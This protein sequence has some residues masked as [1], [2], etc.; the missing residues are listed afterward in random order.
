M[1]FP[2]EQKST[3]VRDIIITVGRTGALT[4]SAVLAPVLVGGVTVTKATLHNEDE[5]RRKDVHIGDHV[6]VQRAG[7][8]IPEIVE[9]VL[10]KRTGTERPFVMPTHCPA[11]NAPAVRPEGEAVARCS[12]LVDC[13][14]QIRQGIIH[15]CSRGA[16]DIDGLGEKL[17]DQFVTVG[18]VNTVADLYSLTHAQLTDLERI[19]DKSAQNLVDAIHE[20]KRGHSTAH[21]LGLAFA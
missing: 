2:P 3:V 21:Y 17:V 5:V 16:L 7:D 19:G 1:K 9:V 11:C 12:H 4:P 18:Y 20:S 8:V 10:S 15:W 6:I 14:A 13:P